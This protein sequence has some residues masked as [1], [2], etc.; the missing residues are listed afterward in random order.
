M[1]IGISL[2]INELDKSLIFLK[3][4]PEIEHIQI[5]YDANTKLKDYKWFINEVKKLYQDISFSIHAYNEINFAEK[6]E[7]VF[8]AWHEVARRTV[9]DAIKIGGFFV[10]FHFG[11]L[12]DGASINRQ[13]S[14][15]KA[16]A[17]FTNLQKYAIESNL[18]IHIENIYSTSPESE[19]QFL[20]DKTEDFSILFAYNANIY[21]CYDFG[22]GNISNLG[23]EFWTKNISRIRSFHVHDNNGVNDLHQPLGYGSINW[24]TVFTQ[25]K[26]ANYQ[27]YFILEHNATHYDH[28]LKY[29]K[30][31][32]LI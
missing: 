24:N 20:G 30:Q 18:E 29:L 1:K 17:E 3:N 32:K 15:E 6:N 26:R 21:I 31:H 11:I 16:I 14:R 23:Y 7:D 27:Y 13:C 22:H 4:N 9:E 12:C 19:Y 5:H 8:L 2:D 10:N 25:L 28:S